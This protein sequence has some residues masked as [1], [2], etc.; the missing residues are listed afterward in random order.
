MA[1]TVVISELTAQINREIDQTITR[2]SRGLP[3]MYRYAIPGLDMP[4]H[5]VA[6]FL[7]AGPLLEALNSGDPRATKYYDVVRVLT[8]DLSVLD[9]LPPDVQKIM[10]TAYAQIEVL[11]STNHQA[12]NQV[13]STRVY[14]NVISRADQ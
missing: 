1:K 14:S 2:M 5:D 3:D 6:R 10:R 8:R 13:G 7:Y 9:R 11:D 4:L 12:I